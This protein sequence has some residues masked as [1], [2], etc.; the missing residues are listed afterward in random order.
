[1]HRT[2]CAA[3]LWILGSLAGT[4]AAARV[5]TLDSSN[6]DSIS[7]HSPV[8]RS[9]FFLRATGFDRSAT[10]SSFSDLRR[11]LQQ[12]FDLVLAALA[13]NS[14]RSLEIALDRLETARGDNWSSEEREVWREALGRRRLVN[15]WRLRLYQLR[16][17]FPQNE[18]VADRA[19]PIFVDNHDTACAVGH[20]MRESGWTDAVSTIKRTNNFVYV[21]DVNDGPLVDWILT[22]GLTQEEAALIQP[23]YFPTGVIDVRLDGLVQGGSIIEHGLVFDNFRYIA[24]EL[25]APESFPEVPPPSNQVD[26]AYFGAGVGEGTLRAG[27]RTYDLVFENWILLG[28]KF[29]DYIIYSGL[30]LDDWGILYSYDVTPIDP[31]HRIVGASVESFPGAGNSYYNGQIDIDSQIYAGDSQLAELAI[32]AVGPSPHGTSF[33]GQDSTLFLPQHKITV[34]TAVHLHGQASIGALFHSFHV[35]APEPSAAA[36][37]S[38]AFILA[39]QHWRR[40]FA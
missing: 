20:L 39:G 26:L 29:E 2:L 3:V 28:A 27:G 7:A 38:I 4:P 12:H 32:G 11:Q 8:L 25:D 15:M 23:G 13:A 16:G 30:G 14:S 21:N 17:R 19:V 35:A 34:V 37:A 18:H 22:S 36:L 33:M 31:A 1:M 5:F 40:R 9:A 10:A 24:G 6:A